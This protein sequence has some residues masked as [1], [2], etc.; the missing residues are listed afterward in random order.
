[1]RSLC[2]KILWLDHGRQVAFGNNVQG[3]CDAYQKYLDTKRLP[4][5]E[6]LPPMN[7]DDPKRDKAAAPSLEEPVGQEGEPVP[8]PA[9]GGVR[10]RLPKAVWI[11]GAVVLALTATIAFSEARLPGV[12]RDLP[13]QQERVLQKDAQGDAEVCLWE[14]NLFLFLDRGYVERTK[15]SFVIT[16]TDSHGGVT[17]DAY[18]VLNDANGR[19]STE[20]RLVLDVNLAR[21][22]GYVEVRYGLYADGDERPVW[23]GSY[24]REAYG[25]GR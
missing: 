1:M 22:T 18:D 5:A 8:G 25:M 9:R 10:R 3:L 19:F 16:A 23:E 12:V 7:V 21:Y 11:A 14:N 4:A 13:R 20:D 24:E 15:P 2:N 17:V 6:E